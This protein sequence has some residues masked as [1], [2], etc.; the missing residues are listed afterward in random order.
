MFDRFVTCQD[1]QL[2]FM[3]SEPNSAKPGKCIFS[4][5]IIDVLWG[6]EPAAIEN[7][8]ITTAT[9]GV[10]VRERTAQRAKD[11][12]LKLYPQ[13]SVDPQAVVLYD[14]AKP[15][16]PKPELQPWPLAG[17]AAVMGADFPGSPR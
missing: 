3:V 17:S 6:I 2:G 4:G 9:F 12:H 7:G 13:C 8:V 16:Q 5:V 1:G 14:A 15:P 11:Y 10:C